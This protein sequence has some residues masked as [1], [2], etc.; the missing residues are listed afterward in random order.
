MQAY[1]LAK[2]IQDKIL[3]DMKNVFAN[4]KVGKAKNNLPFQKGILVSTNALPLLFA[5]LKKKI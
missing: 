1:G 4:L 2:D 3:G 5:D